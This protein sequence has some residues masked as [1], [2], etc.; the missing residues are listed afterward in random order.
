MISETMIGA[1]LCLVRTEACKEENIHRVTKRIFK[2]MCV[3]YSV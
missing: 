1:Q 2:C 3:P